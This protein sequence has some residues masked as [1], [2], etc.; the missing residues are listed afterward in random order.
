[1]TDADIGRRPVAG[2]GRILAADQASK[3]GHEQRR[4]QSGERPGGA[5][6]RGFERQAAAD[7]RPSP[8]CVVHARVIVSELS[9]VIADAKVTDPE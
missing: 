6:P 9:H 5:E 3:A 2:R 4:D 7:G 8:R 1:M